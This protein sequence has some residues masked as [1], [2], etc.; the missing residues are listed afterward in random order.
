MITANHTYFMLTAWKWKWCDGKCS[1]TLPDWEFWKTKLLFKQFILCSML[2]IIMGEFKSFPVLWQF[3]SILLHNILAMDKIINIYRRTVVKSV[4]FTEPQVR[5]QY[6]IILNSFN[7]CSGTNCQTL[8][9][10][11][12]N[13]RLHWFVNLYFRSTACKYRFKTQHETSQS[14]KNLSDFSDF[15]Y[16]V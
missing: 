4:A 6:P 12:E 16:C 8:K 1:V 5:L 15:I 3:D 7:R 10:V 11:C 14:F 9:A 2:L 13:H